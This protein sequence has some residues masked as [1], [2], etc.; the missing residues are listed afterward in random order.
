MESFYLS[1]FNS[2]KWTRKCWPQTVA[3]LKPD[4]PDSQHYEGGG[5][6]IHSRQ[7]EHFQRNSHVPL[8]TVQCES[9]S[10]LGKYITKERSFSNNTPE[11]WCTLMC[12][13]GLHAALADSIIY[14]FILGRMYH[15]RGFRCGIPW[16]IIWKKENLASKIVC[17]LLPGHWAALGVIP[18]GSE[19]FNSTDVEY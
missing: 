1:L 13:L 7:S 14:Y 15:R 11:C 9:V 3:Y 5:N 10:L 2:F 18:E 19:H 12:D 8:G 4:R 17:D 16:K 6:P